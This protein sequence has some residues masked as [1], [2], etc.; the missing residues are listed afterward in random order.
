M[1]ALAD[2]VGDP[3]AIH[4]GAQIGVDAG[5]DDVDT[6]AAEI[7]AKIMHRA[8]GGEVDRGDRPGID[9]QPAHRRRRVRDQTAHLVREEIGV[10]IEQIGAE[11]VD[12]QSGL[13]L[14]AWDGGNGHPAPRGSRRLD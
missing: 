8:S 2:H 3:V 7:V 14:H 1:R 4:V 11:M 5:K 10:G 12:D 6:G 9:H 13:G